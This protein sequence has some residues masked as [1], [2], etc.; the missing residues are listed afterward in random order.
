MGW[1]KLRHLWRIYPPR[2]ADRGRPLEPARR[3]PGLHHGGLPHPRPRAAVGAAAA[4]PAGHRQAARHPAH[5]LLGLCGA[6]RRPQDREAR[7]LQQ[8]LRGH[9]RQRIRRRHGP[10]QLDL[11]LHRLQQCQLRSQRDQEPRPDAEDRRAAGSRDRGCSLHA[12]QRTS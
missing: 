12:G 10:V 1:L 8:R 5:R 7:Q 11:E 9:H 3:R 4:E 2:R 6:G